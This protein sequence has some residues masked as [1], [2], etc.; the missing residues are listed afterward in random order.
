MF[1]L[2]A[3]FRNSG[4]PIGW[5]EVAGLAVIAATSGCDEEFHHACF[6]PQIDYGVGYF[7]SLSF[8]CL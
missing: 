3:V 7:T 2:L 8:R 6:A 1:N 5:Y 4:L